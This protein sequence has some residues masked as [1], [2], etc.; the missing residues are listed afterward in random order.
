MPQMKLGM[1]V[2]KYMITEEIE[3]ESTRNNDIFEK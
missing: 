2:K 1:G 3:N